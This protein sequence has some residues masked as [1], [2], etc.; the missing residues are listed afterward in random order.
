MIT[1]YRT[2]KVSKLHETGS[3]FNARAAGRAGGGAAA[4]TEPCGVSISQRCIE[5]LNDSAGSLLKPIKCVNEE[6]RK[7]GLNVR[8]GEWNWC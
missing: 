8:E 7:L 2:I 6:F 4:G 5:K 1:R 3:T